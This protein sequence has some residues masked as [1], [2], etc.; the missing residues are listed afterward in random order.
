MVYLEA[1]TTTDPLAEYRKAKKEADLLTETLD[2]VDLD[3]DVY[4]LVADE[5]TAAQLRADT[6]LRSLPEGQRPNA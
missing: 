5:A 2:H 3:E 1:P 4:H 6:L